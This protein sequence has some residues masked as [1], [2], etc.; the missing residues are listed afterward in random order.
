MWS[1]IAPANVNIVIWKMAV[2][3]T[4]IFLENLGELLEGWAGKA[5]KLGYRFRMHSGMDAVDD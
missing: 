2:P 1:L 4:T 3:L 5:N